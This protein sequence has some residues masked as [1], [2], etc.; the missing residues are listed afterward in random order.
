MLR[1]HLLRRMVQFGACVAVLVAWLPPS[2]SAPKRRENACVGAWRSAEEMVKAGHMREAK[3]SML[4]CAQASCSA[5]LRKECTRRVAEI[6]SDIPSIVPIVTDASGDTL[7]D[8]SVSMD[9]ESLATRIDGRALLVDPG[10]HEFTFKTSE[11]VLASYKTVIAQGQRNRTIEIALRPR[12]QGPLV[13]TR[14]PGGSPPMAT[15]GERR[16]QGSEVDMVSAGDAGTSR[17]FTTG[18]YALAGLGALGIAGYA[19]T[20]YWGNRDNQLLNS[21]RPDCK[22]SSVDHIRQLYLAGKV[23]LG[24]GIAALAGATYLY[25]TSN[26]KPSAEMA[27][28]LPRYRLDVVPA[29]SGGFAAFSGSF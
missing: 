22:Q 26:S 29:A 10:A 14:V 4:K 9:D 17:Y 7:T 18:T 23:S 5:L 25:V 15:S 13:R 12:G 24:L 8:V 2:H 1:M 3:V 11:G 21:C 6:E 19:L 20:T 16:N 28:N 27:L